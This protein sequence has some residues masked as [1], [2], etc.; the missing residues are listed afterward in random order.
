LQQTPSMQKLLAQSLGPV[1]CWPFALLQ[2][3]MASGT[4]HEK[5]VCVHALSQQTLPMQCALPHAPSP[6]QFAPR[7]SCG[8]HLP[9]LQKLPV[10]QSASFE[11]V[12]AQAFEP[13][14]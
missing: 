3:P 13:H 6:L 1:H 4:L 10:V 8:T 7:P 5:P 9:P 12:V 14:E 11:H 2:W